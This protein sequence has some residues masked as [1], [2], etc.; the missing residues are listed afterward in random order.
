MSTARSRQRTLVS[1][2]LYDGASMPST[3]LGYVVL[4]AGVEGSYRPWVPA[5]WLIAAMTQWTAFCGSFSPS[6]WL[7][8]NRLAAAEPL[9]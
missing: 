2:I 3:V 6:R 4:M 9:V 7:N 8:N 1:Y 5:R